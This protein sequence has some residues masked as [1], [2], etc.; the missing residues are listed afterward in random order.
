MDNM[1][2][3]VFFDVSKKEHRQHFNT[4]VLSNTW[5]NS[6]YRFKVPGTANPLGTMQRMMLEYYARKELKLSKVK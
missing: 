2:P 4:F 3:E 6:P 5:G 1:R